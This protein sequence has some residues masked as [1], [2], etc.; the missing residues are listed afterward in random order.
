[1]KQSLFLLLPLIAAV[2]LATSCSKDDV[3]NDTVTP[4][5]EP[6]A[7]PYTITVPTSN[8]LTKIG[9]KDGTEG[10]NPIISPCF[11]ESDKD[12]LK[13]IVTGE[14]IDK[15]ELTLIEY[16]DGAGTFSGELKVTGKPD[17]LTATINVSGKELP[18][19]SSSGTETLLEIIGKCAHSF[20]GDFNY[21][22][23]SVN[24]TD[25]NVYLIISSPM[26]KVDIN[27]KDYTLDKDHDLYVA[28]NEDYISSLALGLGIHEKGAIYRVTRHYQPHAFTVNAEGKTVTFSCG[29]LQYHTKQDTWRFAPHQYDV[30]HKTDD[31]VGDNYV[32]WETW[33]D[34]FG[35][36]TW[37]NG[38]GVEEPYETQRDDATSYVWSGE[39][40]IGS[41]WQ[42]LSGGN[43]EN[44]EWYYLFFRRTDASEKW[45][46]GSIK[47]SEGVTVNGVIILPDDWTTPPEGCTFTKGE[48]DWSNSYTAETW[49][50]MESV[51]AVFL[52]TT[53]ERYGNIVVNGGYDGI[54]WSSFTND[55]G[56][57]WY[58]HFYSHNVKPVKDGSR[59][60][61]QSVRLVRAWK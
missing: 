33:T 58:A 12:I 26:D 10:G 41:E 56:T 27:G 55:E 20:S 51:G 42:T 2:T 14:G 44:A 3:S 23:E 6:H 7:N 60:S 46:Q 5:Q 24:L 61:G 25:Q 17:K 59:W 57:A 35:W 54:Y 11:T 19:S 34:L 8:K 43:S 49:A 22:D 1:M 16:T 39:S 18:Y 37:L 45:G 50:K 40:A 53:G 32:S 36:G 48:S 4:A 29:N 28:L 38:T 21:G 15:S 52:P 47:V 9:F 30:C 31:N 13:M